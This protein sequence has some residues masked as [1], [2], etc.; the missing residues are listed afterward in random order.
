MEFKE[1]LDKYLSLLGTTT[2]ELAERTGLAAATISRYHT[3]ERLPSF[4]SKQLKDLV[5]GIVEMANDKGIA[6]SS[7]AVWNDFK[8]SYGDNAE[9][10]EVIRI[11]T[12]T[13]VETLEINTNDISKA[14]GLS[15]SYFSR[16]CSGKRNPADVNS[17]VDLICKYITTTYTADSEVKLIASILKKEPEEYL[18]ASY[19]LLKTWLV[20]NSEQVVPIEA[21]LEKLDDF[22]LNEYITTIKFDKIKVPTVPFQIPSS[23]MYYGLEELKEGEIDFFKTTVLSKNSGT[24]FMFNDMPMEDMSK[25]M[26]F[27]KKWMIAIAMSLKKGLHINIVHNLDRPFNE[28]LLGLESWIPM[29]MTGQISPYYF[30]QPTSQ[31]FYH[32]LYTSEVAALSGSGIRG[33]HDKASYYFTSKK[34]E[35]SIYKERE[36]ALLKKASPLMDIY[37]ESRISEF[38][39]FK[40][41]ELELE[42]DNIKELD[43]DHLTKTFKNMKFTICKNKWLIITKTNAPTIHFVIYHEKLRNTIENFIVPYVE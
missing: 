13:L 11:N 23:K 39:E 19:E 34:N 38:E 21:F 22:D 17:F 31:F 3:G 25:D 43:N 32:T 35:I 41:K 16:I 8:E 33:Q 1:V 40:K 36:E 2:K 27:G 29:Y 30:T 37:D 42:G 10:F 6:L 20:K 15:S 4:G 9:D 28:L 14:L 26:D 24:I 12:N 5:T 7:E 18:G